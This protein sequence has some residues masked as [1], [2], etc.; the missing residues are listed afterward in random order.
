[1]KFLNEKK[2]SEAGFTLVE[3]MIVV[4]IIG[5]LSAVAIP[6]FKKY[7]AKAKTSEAKIQLAAAYTAEQAFYGDFGIYH[8]CLSYMGFDP[9]RETQARYFAIGFVTEASNTNDP[10]YASARQ[11][12]LSQA[13]CQDVMA[14]AAGTTYFVA[15]KT[16]GQAVVDT[17]VKF[18]AAIDQLAVPTAVATGSCT[19]DG[20]GGGTIN[21]DVTASCLGTQEDEDN[22]AFVIPAAGYID[23]STATTND[24]VGASLWT[25]NSDKKIVNHIT[26][27]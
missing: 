3:L 8:Q 25:I 24:G 9:S 4:A 11:N 13:Q 15:G 17:D 1:M 20:A 7:Q 26:G 16:I 22:M 6:N 27:Y 5:V 2:A 19:T 14:A 12:G 21:T 10:A 18:D 23:S